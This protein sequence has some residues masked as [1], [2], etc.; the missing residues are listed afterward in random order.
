MPSVP[1][2]EQAHSVLYICMHR[3][4]RT[5]EN[6]QINEIDVIMVALVPMR[7]YYLKQKFNY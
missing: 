5:G 6:T 7:P 4:L 1:E 2:V 3:A